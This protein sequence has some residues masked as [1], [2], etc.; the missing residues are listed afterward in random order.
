MHELFQLLRSDQLVKKNMQHP[1]V[2]CC[3]TLVLMM[4][5]IETLVFFWWVSSHLVKP[6]MIGFVLYFFSTL[7]R[8]FSPL[9]H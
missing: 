2:L 8:Y 7:G 5:T 4:L 6:L 1:T 9:G 3:M